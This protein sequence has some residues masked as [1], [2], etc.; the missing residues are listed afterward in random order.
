MDD[1]LAE[2]PK[3]ELHLHLEGAVEPATLVELRRLHGEPATL[4]ETEA[5]YRYTDF[6]SF[7]MAFRDVSVHLLHLPESGR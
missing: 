4:A 1:F 7:L 5:L 2:L 3:A 6:P